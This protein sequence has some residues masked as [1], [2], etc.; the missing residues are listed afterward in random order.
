MQTDFQLLVCFLKFLPNKTPI[1]KR[2]LSQKMQFV[3]QTQQPPPPPVPDAQ[4]RFLLELKQKMS[5]FNI[6]LS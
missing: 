5:S 4:C 3:A 6:R 2:K 1:F